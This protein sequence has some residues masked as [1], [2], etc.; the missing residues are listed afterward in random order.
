MH[1]DIRHGT[2]PNQLVLLVEIH[3]IL[4]AIVIVPML[5]S[6]RS[7]DIFLPTFGRVWLPRCGALARFTPRFLPGYSVTSGP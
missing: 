6:P 3:M 5:D 7:V 4:L 1:G 2:A